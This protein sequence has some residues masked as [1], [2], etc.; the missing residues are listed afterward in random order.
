[1]MAIISAI[2]SV[3]RLDAFGSRQ[4]SAFTS[5]WKMRVRPS[6]SSRIVIPALG[7]AR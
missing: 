6:V 2:C 7:G 3:A 5:A 1:M 4:P